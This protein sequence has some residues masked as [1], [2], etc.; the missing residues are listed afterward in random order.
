MEHNPVLQ[1]PNTKPNILRRVLQAVVL[2]APTWLVVHA[3]V[4]GSL[5]LVQVV[6]LVKH[7]AS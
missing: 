5:V 3:C 7:K 1:P 4:N 6:K 2:A